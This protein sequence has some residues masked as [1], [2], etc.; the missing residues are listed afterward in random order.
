MEDIHRLASSLRWKLLRHTCH[1]PKREETEGEKSGDHS[2][3]LLPIPDVPD[4]IKELVAKLSKALGEIQRLQLENQELAKKNEQRS[5]QIHVKNTEL[6]AVR[7]ELRTVK[8][9]KAHLQRLYESVGQ[10]SKKDDYLL[11]LLRNEI[12]LLKTTLDSAVEDHHYSREEHSKLCGLYDEAVKMITAMRDDLQVKNE[13]L[14]KSNVHVE[15][16]EQLLRERERERQ[17]LLASEALLSIRLNDQEDRLQ[18]A[19]KAVLFMEEQMVSHQHQ[20][21][22]F[23]TQVSEL[24][25]QK[26]LSAEALVKLQEAYTLGDSNNKQL[27]LDREREIASLQCRLIELA[28]NVPLS[29]A[30]D[31]PASSAEPMTAST[32]AAPNSVAAIIDA[33]SDSECNCAI[34]GETPYGVMIVCEGCQRE[35]HSSC[36]KKSGILRGECTNSHASSI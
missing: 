33:S 9:E 21:D 11:T 6:H 28:A 31:F 34:C 32:V 2:E 13:K 27:L 18:K 16:M 12:L 29:T 19:E 15:E 35:H 25:K 23:K 20:I 36:A 24:E 30:T 22:V 10:D 14:L 3:V 1:R 4:S 26:S 5:T 7:E 17:G 8:S